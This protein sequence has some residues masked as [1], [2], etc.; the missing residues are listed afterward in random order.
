MWPS[1][2][3]CDKWFG[4]EDRVLLQNEL[5]YIGISEYCGLVLIWIVPRTDD[6][7]RNLSENWCNQIAA[8]FLKEFSE[9]QPI[10]RASN[11]VEFFQKNEEKIA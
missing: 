2:D 7:R 3:N 9:Y 8:R 10:A 6:L 11:G 5:S 1:F 4:R